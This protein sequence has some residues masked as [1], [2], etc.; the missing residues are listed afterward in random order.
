MSEIP[1]EVDHV[2]VL[3]E[4]DQ[5]E[6]EEV[7]HVIVEEEEVEVAIEEK[8]VIEAEVQEGE[9]LLIQ[10]ELN[11]SRKRKKLVKTIMRKDIAY[12]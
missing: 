3:I 1:E 5:I 4:T 11:Q 12:P 9:V 7:D 8:I 6:T 10:E 2:I